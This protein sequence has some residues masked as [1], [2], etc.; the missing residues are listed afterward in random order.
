MGGTSE[1]NMFLSVQIHVSKDIIAEAKR[2]V[3]N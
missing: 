2:L 3:L 1:I